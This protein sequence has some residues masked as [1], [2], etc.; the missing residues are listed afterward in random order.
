[1]GVLGD[2]KSTFKDV[3]AN[4]TFVEQASGETTGAKRGRKK[5]AKK[6]DKFYAFYCTQDELYELRRIADEKHMTMGEYF[7]FKLFN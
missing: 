3:T 7:R 6:R 5:S 4:K 1:M 2:K